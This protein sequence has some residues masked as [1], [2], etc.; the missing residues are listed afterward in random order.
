MLWAIVEDPTPPLAPMK[1]MERPI[2]SDSGIDEDGRNHADN[3]G[4]RDR[5]HHIFRNAGAD[6]LAI[7][8]DVVVVADDH[9]LGGRIAIF[10]KLPQRFKKLPRLAARFH[11]DQIGRRRRLVELD[12]RRDPAHMDL[13]MRLRHAAV[14]AGT[15]DRLGDAI[16]F[17]ERLDRDARHGP[18]R[19]HGGDLLPRGV[20][21]FDVAIVSQ[22]AHVRLPPNSPRLRSRSSAFAGLNRLLVFADHG[23][24]VGSIDRRSASAARADR[25]GLAIWAATLF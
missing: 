11:D 21:V 12:C 5:R 25:A 23:A 1:A 19:M 17:A 13:E 22:I 24:A 10:G 9:D 3:V 7:E 14:L 15:L 16:G 4:H 2:G 6:Q 18:Q 8:T 20:A